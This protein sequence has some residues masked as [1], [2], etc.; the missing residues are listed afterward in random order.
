[1]KT[2]LFALLLAGVLSLTML[3]GCNP[4]DLERKID[5]MEDSLEQRF[6]PDPTP[7]A[8]D[9]KLTVEEAKDIALKHAGLT[10]D[11]VRFI[12]ADFDIDH[13]VGEFDIEFDKGNMEYEYEIHADTGEILSFEQDD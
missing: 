5:S 8:N 12:K 2:R 4:R 6:D 3:V 9:A 13:G 1:M 10:A 7:S 11:E